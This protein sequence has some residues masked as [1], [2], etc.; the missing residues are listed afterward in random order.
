[1]KKWL[2]IVT[3]LFIGLISILA[4]AW[5]VV[6]IYF[7]LHKKE[8]L[9]KAI[10]A[11]EKNVNGSITV[12]DIDLSFPSTFPY[13]SAQL[14]NIV[15]RDSLYNTHKHNLLD[16]KQVYLQ[17]NP[18]AALFGNFNISRIVVEDGNIFAFEDAAGYSNFSAINRPKKQSED[19]SKKKQINISGL[20]L[21]NVHIVFDSHFK[22]KLYDFTVDNLTCKINSEGD[23]EHFRVKL[24]LVVNTLGFD[25]TKG[26][27]AK[28]QPL[29]GNLDLRLNKELMLL[30]FENEVLRIGGEPYT[31]SGKFH[32]AGDRKFHLDVTAPRADFEKTIRLLP[33]NVN[34]SLDFLSVA[35]TIDAKAT[36]DGIL[37]E[38]NK[39]F[40]KVDWKVKNTAINTPVGKLTNTS[41]TG[42][43]FNHVN[44]TVEAVPEN[45]MIQV[46]NFKGDWQ[47]VGIEVKK[48]SFTNLTT[49]YLYCELKTHAELVTLNNVAPTATFLF[50]KGSVTTDLVYSG[51]VYDSATSEVNING[52]AYIKDASLQ[53]GP[54]QIQLDQLN[55]NVVF[56]GTDVYLRNVN[57]LA[58]GNKIEMTVA[59]KN[60]LSLMNKNPSKAILTATIYSPEIDISKFTSFIG[61]RKQTVNNKSSNNTFRKSFSKIDNLLEQCIIASSVSA[62]KI[63]FKKFTA[64]D[65]KTN[66]LLT[67]QVWAITG[68]SFKHAGGSVNLDGEMRG[69]NKNYNPIKFK[70]DLKSIDIAALFSS[71]NNF[72]LPSLHA[73]NLR[74]K[75]TSTIKISGALLDKAELVP[76]SLKGSISLSLQEGEL[77]N[78]EPL[79]SLSVFVLK[80]RNFSH[81]SFSELHNRFD[82]DGSIVNVNRMEIQSNVLQLFME[83]LYDISGKST[84]LQIQVP[85]SNLKK[86]DPNYV[87]EKRGV[88]GK[89]GV[90]VFVNAK[91]NDKGDISFSYSLF[92]KKIE[93]KQ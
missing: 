33:L 28:N 40:V 81:I 17:I 20:R 51:P 14:E 89:N 86:R 4:I 21:V 83:G 18:F 52:N 12:S 66:I 69:G 5:I 22:N 43:F 84:N 6:Y 30:S 45:S 62:S 25:L 11:V 38:G 9:Q 44:D 46:E 57:A 19:S 82:I 70:A 15:L 13:I 42:F 65:L 87:P 79:E 23:S 80:N 71:F 73:S 56:S 63:K 49:P 54:R 35:K 32:F 59:G 53:Y 92:H 10:A 3:K 60:L 88:N 78:F 74:G 2:I 34:T 26:S 29:T 77:N 93:K 31:F 55:G 64:T 67:N 7:R 76:A 61:T 72:N 39:A 91:S 37:T 58:Q 36:V 85:L 68:T 1:L 47:G 90:S 8:L 16:A 75:L 27:F 50:K 41:F 48:L 24:N